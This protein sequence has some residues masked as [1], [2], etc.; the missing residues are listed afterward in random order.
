MHHVDV[1]IG[2][3]RYEYEVEQLT[4]LPPISYLS[5]LIDDIGKIG[6]PIDDQKIYY[7]SKLNQINYKP[8]EIDLIKYASKCYQNFNGS[9][10]FAPY[11]PRV[12]K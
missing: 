10:M 6:L 1:K 8:S 3:A 12:E 4:R 11:M 7:Y 2:K 5:F 9:Q